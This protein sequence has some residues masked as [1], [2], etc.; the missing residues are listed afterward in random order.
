LKD[1]LEEEAFVGIHV[2]TA[3]ALGIEDGAIVRIV[4]DA[5][6]AQAPVRVASEVAPGAAFVPFNQPGLPANRLLS[7]SFVTVAIL[8][9]VN[10]PADTPEEVP[11]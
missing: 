9:S 1:A 10:A 7:G 6:E 11:A 3:A 4:T 5:G 2:D 8:E